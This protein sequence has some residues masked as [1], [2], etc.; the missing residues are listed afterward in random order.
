M[1]NQPL[2]SGDHSKIIIFI[3][4]F[5]PFVLFFGFGVIPAIFLIFGIFMMKKNK[6]FNHI[7]TAVNLFRGYIFLALLTCG[8]LALYWYI[9]WRIIESQRLSILP[10]EPTFS[11]RLW[12]THSGLSYEYLYI[13]LFFTSILI[14]YLV[15][16]AKLFYKPLSQHKE[17]VET[18]GIFATKPSIKPNSES[19]VN[20]IKG[21]ELKQYSVADELI[22]WAKLKEG[23]HISE[24]EFR[25]ARAKILKRE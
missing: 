3:L 6:D 1:V 9:N 10:E 14:M 7:E 4:L 17:W 25:E 23:G 8:G 21:E 5:L 18:N 24:D 13:I 16:I 11:E 19:E 22:K 2:T 12:Y 15:L 20:I